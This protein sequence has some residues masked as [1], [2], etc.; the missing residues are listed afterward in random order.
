M[1]IRRSHARMGTCGRSGVPGNPSLP[2]VV[3]R[4]AAVPA[5][6]S[7]VASF[8]TTCRSDGSPAFASTVKPSPSIRASILVLPDRTQPSIVSSPRPAGGVHQAVHEF[9]AYAP[10]LPGI[11]NDDCELAAP[12]VRIDGVT[13]YADFRFVAV[14]ADDRNQ[15]HLLV[16]I[17]LCEARECRFAEIPKSIEKTKIA[18]FVGEVAHK[19]P[20]D[21]AILRPNRTNDDTSAVAQRPIPHQ[22][23]RVGYF[24]SHVQTQGGKCSKVSPMQIP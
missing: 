12:A 23:D 15:R 8:L 22:S 24:I 9:R 21:L 1:R 5:G 11:G 6:M 2:Q 3:S 4:F 19:V 16:V 18:R 20:L 7:R 13:G 10:A 14:L 17:D